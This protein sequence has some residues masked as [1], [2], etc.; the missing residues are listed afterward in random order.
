MAARRKR[1]DVL[2]RV[3]AV[4]RQ[5]GASPKEIKAAVETGLVESGLRNLPGGDADS[6]GWRQERAS[7]YPN[8]TNVEASARRF[9]SEARAANI[10][11]GSAGELAA[12]VQRP[13]AQ[14]R[15]RYAERSVEADRL[16]GSAGSRVTGPQNAGGVPL[17]GQGVRLGQKTVFDR[18]GFEQ[19]QRQALLAGIIA[20]RRGTNNPLFRSGLLSTAAPDRADF[21]KTDVTSRIVDGRARASAATPTP[22]GPV[23]GQLKE[24]FWQGPGGINIKNGQHVPQG[25]VDGHTNHVHVAA[26]PRTIVALGKTAQKL[27]LRVGENSNFNGGRRVTAGHAVNS[28]H[29]TDRAIDVSGDP[30]QMRHF[31]QWVAGRFT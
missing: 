18:V 5:V 31:A 26:G 16:L 27:G 29:Y 8:P 22:A 2:A 25:F 14:Y 19:A 30:E 20:K 10:R 13:A 24:L 21:T 6:A 23:G 15:G 7:L 9:F 11:G 12:R 1:N 3:L 28:F 17:A 4:G